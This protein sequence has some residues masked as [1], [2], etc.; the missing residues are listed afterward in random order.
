MTSRPI[1]STEMHDSNSELSSNQAENLV[2]VI[3]PCFNAERT[4]S[5]CLDSLLSQ[6]EIIPHIVCV[7]DGSTDNTPTIL[8]DYR[9]KSP[10]NISVVN[11]INSGA[12]QARLAGLKATNSKFIM[13][14]DSDDFAKPSFVKT[15]LNEIK[16][17]KSDIAVCGFERVDEG[18]GR[19]LSKEFCTPIDS[20]DL[21]E[22]YGKLLKVNPAPWNKIFKSSILTN[23]P[24]LKVNPI[25]LDDLCLLLSGI[26]HPAN[27][28]SFVPCSLIEYR[29]HPDSAINSVNI[30][31]VYDASSA[32]KEVRSKFLSLDSHA[33]EAFDAV[34][35]C[36]LYVSMSFR[37]AKS[38]NKYS[39]E[40]LAILDKNF[41]LWRTSKYLS[42]AY[43]FHHGKTHVR[44]A[45]AAHLVKAG[46][47]N[48]AINSYSWAKKATGKDISW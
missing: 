10:H 43:A 36:H 33:L 22:D 1:F 29:V 25:M 7:N 35:F 16:T 13:F 9:D 18:S 46:F 44:A 40:L 11:Q 28:I 45:I 42:L 8:N 30:E 27:K 23:L 12:W 17:A 24:N 20:F 34:A 21:S 39:N 6:K 37:L 3:I 32:L 14:L 19:V 4:L 26:A 48:Q 31:Q 2:S 38:Q 41:P 5:K 47:F 15:M